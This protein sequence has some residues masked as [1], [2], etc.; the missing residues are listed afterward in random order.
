ME[1]NQGGYRSELLIL[2]GLSDD[3]LL[4]RQIPEE[5]RHS[6]HANMERAK[7][8]LCQCMSRVK[9]NLK[10]VYSKHK[11]VANFSID[12]A[13]YLIPVLTSNPTIPTHL[14]PVL[15]IL[16]MRHGAEFLSEQ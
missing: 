7:D 1:Y 12:F 3:E 8:I 2:S 9:E 6:P 16:I 11:H 5:E 10:E 15:A 13:L 4:E 14:V